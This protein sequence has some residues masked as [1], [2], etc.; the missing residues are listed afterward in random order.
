MRNKLLLLSSIII[1]FLTAC[2]SKQYYSPK[3]I[4]SSS[5][6]LLSSSTIVSFN[7]DGATLRNGNVLT[8]RGELKLNLKKNGFIF[9][10]KTKNGII[11]ANRDGGCQVLKNGK[12]QSIKFSKALLAG[13]VIGNNLIYILRDNSFGIYDLS[14]KSIIYN[15]NGEKVYSIDARVTNPLQV[16]KLVVIPLLNGKITILDL[17]SKKIVKEIFVS[18][19]SSLNNIIF[20][21]QFKNSLIVATPHKVISVSNK[22]RR[23]FEDEISEVA[24]DNRY[25]YI[26]SKDGKISK[27]DNSFTVQDDKKFRFAHFSVAT[28]Y[29]N[30][31]YALDKQGYLIVSNKNFT[32]YKVYKFPE[33]DGYSFVSNGKIYY[34]GNKIELKSLNY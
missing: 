12:S 27:L 34:D 15:N 24:T 26:F 2:S 9:I 25:I 29:K 13:T 4:N 16:D 10:N 30:R 22:G 18:T 5:S 21:K 14:K 8:K 31:V 23:E 11:I 17:K 6:S 7:E 19:Q 20:L 32:K 28:L 1:L 3:H 33:V